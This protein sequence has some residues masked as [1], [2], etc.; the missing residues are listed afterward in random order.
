MIRETTAANLQATLN[1]CEAGDTVRVI[2]SGTSGAVTVPVANVTIE[3]AAG[4]TPSITSMA[5]NL[6]TLQATG[7]TIRGFKLESEVPNGSVMSPA[8]EAY[9]VTLEDCSLSGAWAWIRHT[10]TTWLGGCTL[11]RCTMSLRG[12]LRCGGGAG[13]V[14]LEDCAATCAGDSTT[15]AAFEGN[16]WTVA[17]R[18]SRIA[19]PRLFGGLN[20]FSPSLSATAECCLLIQSA[21]D[22]D[23][24]AV[25]R[26][27]SAVA[28]RRCTSVHA[29]AGWLVENGTLE[30]VGSGWLGSGVAVAVGSAGSAILTR[31][32][33][34]GPSIGSGVVQSGTVTADPRLTGSY[35]P[36][37]GSPWIDAA[38]QM[39][40]VTTTDLGG[41]PIPRG[42]G[43]D[44]GAYEYPYLAPVPEP[45]PEG[46]RVG[47]N[48]QPLSAIPILRGKDSTE[49]PL[50]DIIR[51]VCLS[52]ILRRGWILAPSVG[53]DL[54]TLRRDPVDA[55][56]RSVWMV[57]EA[58]SWLPAGK[59]GDIEVV[60]ASRNGDRLDLR[61]V[62]RIDRARVLLEG[63]L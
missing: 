35:R 36:S 51:R 1:L 63:V 31:C 30:A 60:T 58:L 28:L 4:Q 29:S 49:G 13:N 3:A 38:G 26:G 21:P 48:G 7:A 34:F 44:I 43:H 17:L 22:S 62:L 45:L 59:L 5:S 47:V 19:A 39:T 61:L 18:R 12:L 53:S 40:I 33:V 15:H 11:R 37:L 14:L 57:R 6:V 56:K 54:H 50:A 8:S 2:D 42:E 23:P 52:L 55:E 27:A 24:F 16:S 20:V 25:V 46:W 9:A 10:T 32:G 41:G